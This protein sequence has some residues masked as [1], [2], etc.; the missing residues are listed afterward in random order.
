MNE[1]NETLPIDENELKDTQQTAKEFSEVVPHAQFSPG[2]TE[3]AELAEEIK[4]A[5]EKGAP[6]DDGGPSIDEQAIKEQLS[7]NQFDEVIDHEYGYV[8]KEPPVMRGIKFDEGIKYVPK[9]S[10]FTSDIKEAL[11]NSVPEESGNPEIYDEADLEKKEATN[12]FDEVLRRGTG[13]PA[14]DDSNTMEFTETIPR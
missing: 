3:N 14:A 12:E 4:E 11:E 2:L 1:F 10:S 6:P 7:T 5:I 13:G 8:P 9:D